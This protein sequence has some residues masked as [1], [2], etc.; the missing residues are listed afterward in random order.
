MP[1]RCA[2]GQWQQLVDGVEAAH[3]VSTS[4]W[5]R[6]NG[7]YWTWGLDVV[8]RRGDD[9]KVVGERERNEEAVWEGVLRSGVQWI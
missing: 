2:I 7:S 5:G 3:V 1:R 4:F 8:R 9:T 6:V